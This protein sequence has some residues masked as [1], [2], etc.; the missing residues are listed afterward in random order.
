MNKSEEVF[1]KLTI[2]E[3]AAIAEFNLRSDQLRNFNK[4]LHGSIT[5]KKEAYL[6]KHV[7][8]G[9]IVRERNA[10]SEATRLMKKHGLVLRGGI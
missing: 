7:L 4:V 6:T 5:P 9:Y 8:P 3:R 1:D 2:R 10:R